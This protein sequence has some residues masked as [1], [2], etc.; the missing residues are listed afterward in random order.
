MNY[1]DNFTGYYGLNKLTNLLVRPYSC[2][3]YWATKGYKGHPSAVICWS[4][5]KVSYGQY[6][7]VQWGE[8]LLSVWR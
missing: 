6:E 1:F 8:G 5:S 4:S 7:T 3:T 2:D